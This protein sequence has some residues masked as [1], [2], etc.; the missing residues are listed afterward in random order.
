MLPA[1]PRILL[2]FLKLAVFLIGAAS[3]YAEVSVIT[4]STK[5]WNK[6][7]TFNKLG[8]TTSGSNTSGK[9]ETLA[10]SGSGF[11]HTT[12]PAVGAA[13]EVVTNAAGATTT[14]NYAAGTG[15]VR[16]YFPGGLLKEITLARGG[17]LA[18]GYSNEGAR[19]LTSAT[20]PTVASGVFTIPAV[21]QSYGYDRAGRIDE[22]GDSS[23]ARSL[24]HQNGRLTQT[25]WN[26]GALAGYKV[27]KGID[28]YGRDTGFELWRGNTLIH[29]AQK[30]PN[31]VS[32]EVSELVSGNLKILIGRNAA[33]QI[34]GLQW[35]NSNGTFV[36]VVGQTW[37]RGT[38]GRILLASSTVGG[39]PS[40][41]YRGT[42]NNESTAFDA[43]GRR[44]KVKTAGADWIYQY[45]KGQLTSA[46][47][48]THGSFTYQFDGIGRR[49]ENN[50]NTTDLLN[51][52]LVWT[53]S[54][55]K[56][57]KVAAHPDAKAEQSRAV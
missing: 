30:A 34:T 11:K 22:I 2:F 55:N 25:A 9:T 17:K 23:G 46:V 57:L 43:K 27:V 5:D 41:D 45:G 53:N 8:L 51:R 26:S 37:D 32:G 29:S 6:S 31:D 56:T 20:R 1:L 7:E 3:A 54:Q 48:P 19:D 42:A 36:P 18:F 21:A 50:A 10:T 15:E 13:T 28:G 12:T 14:K 16:E 33:R 44:L 24:V 47:H 49:A 35:G 40:F 39:A 38:A 52:T 4:T